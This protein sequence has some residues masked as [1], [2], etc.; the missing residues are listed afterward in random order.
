M[1]GQT[2]DVR[3]NGELLGTGIVHGEVQTRCLPVR[4]ELRAM[5][6]A[7]EG[8]GKSMEVVM[9]NQAGKSVISL[10]RKNFTVRSLAC[11]HAW[12]VL[13]GAGE[14]CRWWIW[15]AGC[16]PRKTHQSTRQPRPLPSTAL[17]LPPLELHPPQLCARSH[18]RPHAL[19]RPSC[20]AASDV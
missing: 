14:E 4:A 11:W 9:Q 8:E 3:K 1:A 13:T 2:W 18:H 7:P 15:C 5:K 6:P 17:P 12:H 19:T 16:C 10:D 20:V